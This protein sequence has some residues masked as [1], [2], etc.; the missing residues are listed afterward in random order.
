MSSA[1]VV[2]SLAIPIWGRD[3]FGFPSALAQPPERFLWWLLF[4]LVT[5]IGHAYISIAMAAF[6][7]RH[8]AMRLWRKIALYVA[9]LVLGGYVAVP[10][11]F[12]RCRPIL[13]RARRAEG[14]EYDESA[15]QS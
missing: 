12:L 3:Y 5:S 10:Y 6:I 11:Y 7:A 14:V 13:Q 1:L 15:L 4:G 2:A 8:D 9:I